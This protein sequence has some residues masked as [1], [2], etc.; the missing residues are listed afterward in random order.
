MKKKIWSLILASVVCFFLTVPTFAVTEAHSDNQFNISEIDVVKDLQN[1]PESELIDAGYTVE[2]IKEIQNFSFEKAYYERAQLSAEDLRW[3]GYSDAQI[4]ILKSYDGS[5]LEENPQMRAVL[6]QMTGQIYAVSFGKNSM[7]TRFSWEWSSAPIFH[8]EFISDIVSCNAIGINSNNGT[9]YVNAV[10]ANSYANVLYHTNG[11]NTPL[12]N[13]KYE[14]TNNT[15]VNGQIDVKFPMSKSIDSTTG[16]AKSGNFIA[17]YK[18]TVTANDLGA[19]QFVFAYGHAS[20]SVMPS[21]TI[22]FVPPYLTPSVSF[23]IG[24]SNMCSK[25]IILHSDG[26]S[27]TLL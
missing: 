18:E 7:K 16:W 10:T 11:T 27:E 6:A 23:G 19:I 21:V 25:G 9:S 8:G 12:R 15:G 24:T 22:S 13:F 17:E 14:I 2:E 20:V 4:A 3:L 1:T 26:Q 5:P